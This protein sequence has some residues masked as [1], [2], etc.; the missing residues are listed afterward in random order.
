MRDKQSQS[1]GL[2][3]RVERDRLSAD[4]L[5]RQRSPGFDFP[6]PIRWAVTTDDG[7]EAA[8]AYPFAPANTVPIRFL[9]VGYTKTAGLQVLGEDPR[10]EAARTV[11]RV[12]AGQWIP[13]GVP[14]P[15]FE[16]PT[17]TANKGIWHIL[18][19]PRRYYG[20]IVGGSLSAGGSCSVSIWLPTD[21]L[22]PTWEKAGVEL[23]AIDAL[24]AGEE[25][26]EEFTR[27]AIDW[28]LYTWVVGNAACSPDADDETWGS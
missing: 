7:E 12:A 18:E 20:H 28:Q 9:D 25:M 15:V 1:R 10:S 11:A 5:A 24:L 16:Q 8:I 3:S 14:V 23:E 13:P 21:S 19:A 4:Q 6:R 22:S 26:L 17:L 2:Q 27:V